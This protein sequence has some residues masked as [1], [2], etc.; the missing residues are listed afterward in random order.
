MA[1]MIFD[2]EALISDVTEE[3]AAE[4]FKP[5]NRRPPNFAAYQMLINAQP[6]GVRKH[7]DIPKDHPDAAEAARN[8]RYFL[9]EAAKERTVW[10]TAELT[11]DEKAQLSENKR[12]DRFE[13]A[14]G[15]VVTK[16]KDG[17]KTEV[18]EPVVLRWK[19][20]TREEQ[21]EVTEGD[22][23]VTKT[24]KIP[25]RMHYLSVATEAIVHRA[26]RAKPAEATAD[27]PTTNGTEHTPDTVT[28]NGTTALVPEG[29]TA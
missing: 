23:T 12:I 27:A 29:A 25:T 20:D 8:L 26:K 4:I 18:K 17:W 5:A 14:D 9:N 21:R 15:T 22:Q 16:M 2:I 1:D 24:V 28:E 11:D 10:K 7:V 3:E 19:V 13:R 6:L